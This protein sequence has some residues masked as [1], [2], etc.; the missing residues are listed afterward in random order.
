MLK[1]KKNNKLSLLIYITIH[2][3][4]KKVASKNIDSKIKV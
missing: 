2:K 3:R 4:I 1:I